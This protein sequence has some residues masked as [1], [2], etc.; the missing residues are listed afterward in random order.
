MT[1]NSYFTILLA[2]IVLVSAS[3]TRTQPREDIFDSG[4][5]GY[6]MA[7]EQSDKDLQSIA[8]ALSRIDPCG[9][10]DV[11]SIR[12]KFSN[13]LYYGYGAIPTTCA[14]VF[15]ESG[16]PTGKG[17]ITIRLRTD[18][19]N[20]W[21]ASSWRDINVSDIALKEST[22]SCAFYFP[23]NLGSEMHAPASTGARKEYA[24][25]YISI[26]NGVQSDEKCDATRAVAYAAAKV[27]NEKLPLLTGKQAGPS[28]IFTKDPCALY[29]H[30]TGFSRYGRNLQAFRSCSFYKEPDQRF[31]LAISLESIKTLDKSAQKEIRDG[32]TLYLDPDYRLGAY[33]DCTIAVRM[34]DP[35]EPTAVNGSADPQLSKAWPLPVLLLSGSTNCEENK[36]LALTAAKTF[37]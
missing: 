26:T 6:G 16:N 36:N 23:L 19:D 1:K 25:Q 32:I 35:I 21:D 24:K 11:E 15:A 2:L 5:D 14:L 7:Q 13:F 17:T 10:V 12:S 4:G 20:T 29:S 33:R 27:R 37:A 18:I 28:S 34:G 22:D 31:N 30:L 3:C 9:F 8:A